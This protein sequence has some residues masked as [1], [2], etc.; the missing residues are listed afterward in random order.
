IEVKTLEPLLSFHALT[1]FVCDVVS[2][3]DLDDVGL[4][5]MA[6]AWPSL[7]VL[8][9]SSERGWLKRSRVTLDGL[10]CLIRLCPR[11]VQVG[12]V[13]DAS[14]H[15]FLTSTAPPVH[16]YNIVAFSIGN[17]LVAQE[18][19]VA[20]YLSDLTPNLTRISSWGVP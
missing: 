14:N 13:I 1:E 15:T 3:Y 4:T 6:Q 5:R 2:G 12:I 19:W 16:N 8:G 10:T 17:S 20:A 7:Q 18:K 11:L 9:L